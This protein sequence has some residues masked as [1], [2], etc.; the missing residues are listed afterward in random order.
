MLEFAK[1]LDRNAELVAALATL[2]TGVPVAKTRCEVSY[3]CGAQW[4]KDNIDENHDWGDDDI[5][6]GDEEVKDDGFIRSILNCPP[7]NVLLG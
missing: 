5:N 1:L 7:R 3:D 6:V 2:E 4:T